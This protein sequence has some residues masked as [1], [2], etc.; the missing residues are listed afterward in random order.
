[1]QVCQLLRGVQLVLDADEVP[2]DFGDSFVPFPF[3]I[4]GAQFN[5]TN[6]GLSFG[7]KKSP[8][9]WLEISVH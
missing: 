1:M 8:E 5:S 6:F 7:L 4:A 3:P 2:G 9:F